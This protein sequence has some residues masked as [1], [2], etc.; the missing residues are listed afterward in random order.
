MK[1][2][3]YFFKI[4][5]EGPSF[6]EE[7]GGDGG[8]GGGDSSDDMV[9]VKIGNETVKVPKESLDSE[10]STDSDDESG[11][12]GNN[13]EGQSKYTEG[14]NQKIAGK[15]AD[16]IAEMLHNAEKTITTQGKKLGDATK[17]K[18]RDSN[19]VNIEKKDID[20]KITS[21]ESEMEKLDPLVD[22]DKYAKLQGDLKKLQGSSGKL[23]D[24]L[25]DIGLSEKIDAKYNEEYNDTF[26]K[27]SRKTYEEWMGVEIEDENWDAIAEKAKEI[28]GLGKLTEESV[29]AAMIL[30]IGMERYRKILSTQ[31]ELN[32]RTKMGT[33]G[34]KTTKMLGTEQHKGGPVNFDELS[35]K[36]QTKVIAKMKTPEFRKVFK[37][38]YGRYPEDI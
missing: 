12:S 4:A 11:Q 36:Q 25:S 20:G 14:F 21:I 35:E 24:E 1:E 29:E 27:D 10:D 30:D 23:D 8:A 34:N 32:M 5:M 16:E 18:K 28:N 26:L 15:S 13:A 19:T 9:E 17:G 22:V 3:L 37:A 6:G 33:A 2:L 31:G 38:Q 7:D